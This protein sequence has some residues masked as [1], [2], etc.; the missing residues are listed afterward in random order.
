M[1]GATSLLLAADMLT[2]AVA[3]RLCSI[4]KQ[5]VFDQ[6]FPPARCAGFQ[7]AI[8]LHTVSL[9]SCRAELM[10][11]SHF[12]A[13]SSHSYPLTIPASACKILNAYASLDQ[14]KLKAVNS[15]QQ[16]H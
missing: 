16:N 7:L 10:A 2:L 11:V 5:F 6:V 1:E 9:T 14:S 15:S 3:G 13:K 4:W 12:N 8:V